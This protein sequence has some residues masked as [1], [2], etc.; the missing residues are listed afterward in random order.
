MND[1]LKKMMEQ[2]QQ[3]LPQLQE[4]KFGQMAEKMLE[5][6]KK[7]LMTGSSGAGAVKVTINAL[8]A[9]QSIELGEDFS[10]FNKE[11]QEILIKTAVDECLKKF[12]D[13]L[14]NLFPG[15]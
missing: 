11:E 7:S 8:P 15:S 9:V 2:L 3:V 10:K 6:Q 13:Q 5:N 1:E 12:Q 4:G 14:K